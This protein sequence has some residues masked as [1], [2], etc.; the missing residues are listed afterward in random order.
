MEGAVEL[1]RAAVAG[2]TRI[3]VHGD[4]DVDGICATAVMILALR[5][6]G[7]DVSW[8]LPSRFE[9][10]YGL[11][12]ETIDRLA[13]DGVGLIVTV[14]CGI[15]AVDE[16][17]HARSLGLEVV[18]TDHHRPGDALPDCPVVATRPSAYP[19]PDLCGTGVAYKLAGVLL[20]AGHPLLDQSAR[21]RRPRDRR[22]RRPARRREPRAR[23]GGSP[24][25]GA[26]AAPRARLADALRVR[27][28]GGDRRVRDRLPACSAHQCG[29]TARPARRRARAHPRR[30]PPPR[31]R[32]CRRAGTIQPRPPGGRGADRPRRDR[33]DDGLVRGGAPPTRV[34]PLERGLAR[35]CDRDR[36]LEARRAL[37]P[38]GRAHRAK[39]GRQLEGIGP[40]DPVVRPPRRA[41]A[42]LRAARAVRR[43]QRCRRA[44]DRRRPARGIRRGVSPGLPTTSSQPS[45]SAR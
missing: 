12:T 44:R 14:D 45:S 20:G 27:R 5:E 9:E 22:G 6:L 26:H 28:P 31:R 16:V 30:R 34:C 41:D 4:Y 8:H 24:R 13:A 25:T 43:S 35:G 10:G 32:A 40:V 29:R 18:V 37:R 23:G 36:C 33:D 19:F 7:A 21:P 2:G 11:A 1:I 38:A 39:R 15:T 17:A 3:C 42:L